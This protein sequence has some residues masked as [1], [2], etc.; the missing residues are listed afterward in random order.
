MKSPEAATVEDVEALLAEVARHW[1]SLE[2]DRLEELWDKSHPPLYI[3][4]EADEIHTSFEAIRRYWTLTR[5]MMLKMGVEFGRPTILPLGDGL[6]TA[7]FTLHWECLIKGQSAPVGG[8]NR[9]TAVLRRVG[10]HWRFT[11]YV[12]APLAPIVYIR[13]LYERSV[14]PGFGR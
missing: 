11:Q 13:R 3:A 12:E 4:E 9:A 14:T 8:D 1:R 5:G 2:L 6:V 10:D 7:I